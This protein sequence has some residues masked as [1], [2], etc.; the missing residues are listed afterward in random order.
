MDSKAK[1]ASPMGM[2]VDT[3]EIGAAGQALKD[4]ANCW[5]KDCADLNQ[6]KVDLNYN[7]RPMPCVGC[8]LGMRFMPKENPPCNEFKSVRRVDK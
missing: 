6:C 1:T 5:C 8:N 7:I 2:F 3:M 4:C